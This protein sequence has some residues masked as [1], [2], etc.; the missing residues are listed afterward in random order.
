[1]ATVPEDIQEGLK[2]LS[3]AVDV[4]VKS[5]FARMKEIMEDVKGM[6]DTEKDKGFKIRVA[7]GALCN[8]FSSRGKTEGVKGGYPCPL[9]CGGDCLWDRQLPHLPRQ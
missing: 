9:P 7:W 6:G 3:K 8:E 1:M 5:L 2:K 4:P